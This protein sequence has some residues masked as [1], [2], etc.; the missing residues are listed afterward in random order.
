MFFS[1]YKGVRA[2]FTS[3]PHL[4]GGFLRYFSV[5]FG[6]VIRLPIV[7]CVAATYASSSAMMPHRIPDFISSV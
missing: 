6:F 5:I 7:S 3:R 1:L 4:K 2:R